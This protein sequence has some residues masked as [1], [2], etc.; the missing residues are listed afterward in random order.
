MTDLARSV[1]ALGK[2]GT[3]IE[4]TLSRLDSDNVV[5]R[6]WQGD[7]RVWSEDST[8]ILDRLGWL[9]LPKDMES[10]VAALTSFGEQVRDAGFK[11]VVLLGMGGS[12]LG[13]EVLR[14]TF[15]SRAGCPQLLVLDSTLPAWIH[16]V[17]Q[18]IDPATTLFLVSS[19]SGT[20]I[21]SNA[22]FSYFWGRVAEITGDG[23]AGG[24]F[25]AIT[26]P[27]TPLERLGEQEGFRQVF[28]NPPEIGGRYSVL[29]YFG[30]VPAALIGADLECLLGSAAGMMEACTR[31]QA[32]DN[33]GARLGAIMGA[34][35][36][37][38]RDKLTLVTSPAL[39]SFGLWVEQMLAES[40]GKSGKGII[41]VAGEPPLPLGH[42]SDDRLIVYLRLADDDNSSTD[43]LVDALSSS[44]PTVRLELK[45][46]ADLGAEFYR[47]EFA[48]AVAGHILGVHPFDQPNVQGAKDKT[49]AV[50]DQF[51]ST[52]RLPRAE[53]VKSVDNLMSQ[54]NQGD[55]LA[56]LAYLPDTPEIASALASLRRSLT[57]KYGIPTTAG[58]GPRYLHSTGQ[59]HKGGPNSG[60][61][62][63]LT[64]GHSV[65]KPIP[66]WPYDFG[67]LADA[68]S[69]GDL[70]AL[71][72]LGRRASRV[73]LDDD[74]AA[75]IHR[76]TAQVQANF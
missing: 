30:M 51:K 36:L 70:Q 29:S 49:D 25:G 73:H 14:R 45:D 20:T 55:Y 22:L 28:A 56:I 19:K 71:K 42:Y 17:D 35:A 3:L 74:P 75:G 37:E 64:T 41:P 12:S 11:S 38:G 57:E 34:L 1:E 18:A 21:E 13:T 26:D 61:F 63:Q 24:N 53:A 10:K 60:I 8:E 66:G 68:Q 48:T 44:H 16:A 50:L 4:S 33:P 6:I 54:S 23:A 47:W 65:D 46:R 40:L 9:S 52:G 2:Y 32:A 7:H 69:T 72:S 59:L 15:G 43:E 27:G 58:F 62:L 5:A 31:P 67:I 76:I 39:A